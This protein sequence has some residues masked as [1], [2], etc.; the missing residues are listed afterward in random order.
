[1]SDEKKWNPID[2]SADEGNSVV[3]IL[4]DKSRYCHKIEFE[5]VEKFLQHYK[6]LEYF[7]TINT[8]LWATDVPDKVSDPDKVLFQIKFHEEW[9]Q[10]S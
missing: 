10:L 9:P 4:L 3:K 5:L 6:D 8:Y 1:M 2:F 7:Q